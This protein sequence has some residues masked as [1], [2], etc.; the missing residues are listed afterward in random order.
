M[1]EA[2][3]RDDTLCEQMFKLGSERSKQEDIAHKGESESPDD[4]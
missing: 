1:W 3:A 4:E 2:E